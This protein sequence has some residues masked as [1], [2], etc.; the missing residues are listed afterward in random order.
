[1]Q[2]LMH[3]AQKNT[4]KAC[5]GHR[6][7]VE[8]LLLGKSAN[9]PM[10]SAVYQLGIMNWRNLLLH[11]LVVCNCNSCN[12]KTCIVSPACCAA[13]RPCL[14]QLQNCVPDTVPTTKVCC[15]AHDAEC[16]YKLLSSCCNGFWWSDQSDSES[17]CL[18]D[19]TAAYQAAED[20]CKL[21][22]QPITQ[23]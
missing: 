19:L 21:V 16:I 12:C 22:R 4:R 5:S 8:N 6:D 10:Q 15:H 18:T 20:L 2:L 23:T 11:F 13:G 3:V 1:M 9:L 7:F 14:S 17:L